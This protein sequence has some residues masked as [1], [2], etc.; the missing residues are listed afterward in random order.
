MQAPEG[1][2]KMNTKRQDNRRSGGQVLVRAL[3]VHGV[4]LAFGI[5]GESYLAVLDALIDSHVRLIVSR[6]EGAAAM[7]ADA[8]GKLTGRCGIAFVTR[9]PGATNASHGVHIA[10][11]DSTPLILFVGQ[12]G[13]GMIEREAFQEIDYRRMFSSMTKWVAQIDDPARIPE[14]VSH[15][16]HTAL[17]GRPGPVVLALPEDMLTELTDVADAAAHRIAVSGPTPEA[18]AEL[19]AMLE[20]ARRPFVIAGG[21]GW[22]EDAGTAL[23]GFA[24]ANGLPVGCSFRCQSLMDNRHPNY[25]GHVGIGINPKLAARIEAADL[26]IVVGA[27]LGEMTT[28][29]Y[30]LIDS[31]RPRQKMVHVHPGAEELGR[32]YQADLPINA[33]AGAF[34]NG[35]LGLEPVDSSPWAEETRAAHQDYLDHRAPTTTPGALQ[36][37]EVV[38]WLRANTPDETIIANGAGNFAIWINRFF[39]YRG[40]RT[41]LAPTNGSMGYGLPAAIAAKLV[42]PERP[43]VCF[44]GDG[45]FQMTGNELATAAQYRL[46]IVVLIVN[47][48]LYGTIRMHQER[49]YP[50]RA[51]A[52]DLVNPDFVK[53]A[54]AHGG[55]GV[56][57][58]E[59]KDFPGAFEAA[60]KSGKLAV[61]E[62]RIDPEAITPNATLS[63]I[64]EAALRRAGK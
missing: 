31:P 27:R 55:T 52:T 12:V 58:T 20:K 22:D 13:R 11:Q 57:V 1:G 4:D 7:M 37:G 23:A 39:E 5:P 46:P 2:T 9:G 36:M 26:L 62:L 45:D 63:E 8:Y 41:Q 17:S 43:V 32:V 38:H 30:T 29:G 18:L 64:R 16:F 6:H 50:G 51:I 14:Y 47:N 25:A 42:H 49:A 54:Q 48:G 33:G 61:I 15:A 24:E 59:T 40:F 34:L 35:C 21:G 60:V 3:E 19:R 53:L 10:D 56:R 44:T 28:G